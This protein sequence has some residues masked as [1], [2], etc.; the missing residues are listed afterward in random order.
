MYG[1]IIFIEIQWDVELGEL[2]RLGRMV[3]HELEESKNTIA[4]LI[5][6]RLDNVHYRRWYKFLTSKLGAV[7]GQDS[8]LVDFL[9][10]FVTYDRDFDPI[11]N[12]K[13]PRTWVEAAL[14][15]KQ[16]EAEREN[17]TRRDERDL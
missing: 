17:R 3:N 4:V 9:N 1:R 13:Y 12:S 14:L 15:I 7:Y 8:A 6:Q 16:H 5:T 10:R 2:E 11:L